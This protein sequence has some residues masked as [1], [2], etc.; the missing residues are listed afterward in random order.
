MNRAQEKRQGEGKEVGNK[1]INRSEGN[2][3]EGTERS[4][5]QGKEGKQAV[6]R[7][8]GRAGERRREDQAG[9]E[10][11]RRQCRLAG[12]G[13]RGYHQRWG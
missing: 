13:C 11:S 12:R 6:G 5:D 9:T 7:E 2:P 4:G 1:V 8:A 10:K 3:A